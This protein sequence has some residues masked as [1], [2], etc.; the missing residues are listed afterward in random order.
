MS[1]SP[2]PDQTK[3]L[4]IA[5]TGLN[6][7][8]NPGPGLAVIR[9]L[10]DGFGENLRIIG[11]AYET[12]EP[13][14][15][16]SNLVDKTYRIPY[17]TAGTEALKERLLQ[18]QEIEHIDVLIPNFDAELFNFIKLEKE[19]LNM[20]IHTFLPT[21]Q[22]LAARDKVNLRAFGYKHGFDVPVSETIFGVSELD[23][24][25][26]KLSFPLVVKG[27]FYEASVVQNIS[28][29]YKAFYKLQ[30]KWGLP[31]IVQQFIK[32]TEINIAGLADGSG[33]ALSVIPM[34]KLYITEKG[35]AWAGITIADEKLINLAKAFAKATLWKG[36]FEL[37]IMRDDN[38]ALY[39]MEVNPRFPAWI[40][41]S[42]AAGQNQ[43]K[44]LVD[45]ALG[46]P[47]QELTAYT[48][49]KMFVR[50]AWDN[51][52]DVAEFQ[53]LSAFGEL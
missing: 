46:K 49:G 38:D 1:V 20:G 42:A 31:I 45:L 47:V 30:A 9:A 29:A 24:I 43:P 4:T 39:I 37:E 41:L 15:Y 28:E 7:N 18:I 5:V 35:K 52:V 27:K 12:L 6:A 22:Q 8:D 53:K 40:Y 3:A 44:L 32:G 13:A 16:L 10:K 51:I 26:D 14:I 36:G 19:L 34:R 50:Y 33:N 48:A 25:A 11:L 23:Q 21:H 17:P 2:K